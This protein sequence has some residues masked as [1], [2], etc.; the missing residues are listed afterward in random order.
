MS[1]RHWPVVKRSDSRRRSLR[2]PAD[3]GRDVAGDLL[4][5]GG[6]A[7]DAAVTRDAE[8]EEGVGGLYGWTI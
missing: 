6:V 1:F 4:E 8:Q 3:R 7:V 2:L 5:H